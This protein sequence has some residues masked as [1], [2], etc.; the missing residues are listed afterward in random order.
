MCLALISNI[1]GNNVAL[2]AVDLQMF[3]QVMNAS[4]MPH[5]AWWASH[6]KEV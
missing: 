4:G 3:I 1:H 2:E 5:A 6:W